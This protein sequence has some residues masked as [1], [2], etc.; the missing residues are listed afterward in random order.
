MFGDN[1]FDGYVERRNNDGRV[2]W[3]S[4]ITVEENRKRDK[5]K[6]N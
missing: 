5:S 3:I 6:K 2:E 4:E 1:R